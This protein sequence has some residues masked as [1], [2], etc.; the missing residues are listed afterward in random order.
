MSVG[1]VVLTALLSAAATA[2][3]LYQLWRTR[4]MP[5]LERRAR[6]LV[7]EATVTASAELTAAAEAV[8]PQIRDAI[9]AAIREGIQDAVLIPPTERIGQTARGVT[10]AGVNV[11]EA[12]LRRIFGVPGPRPDPAAPADGPVTEP[13][14]R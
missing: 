11:V 6:V 12:S 5:D 4:L 7:D 14:S 10:S 8:V 9:R 2:A 13:E 3:A 1:A